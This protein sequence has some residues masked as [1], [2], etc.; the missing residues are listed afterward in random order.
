L[1]CWLLPQRCM[2]RPEG[3]TAGSQL[4]DASLSAVSFSCALTT[5]NVFRNWCASLNWQCLSNS[6][7]PG[8]RF[9]HKELKDAADRYSLLT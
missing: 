1:A 6:L 3:Q 4:Q 5:R 9:C 2:L 7:D 8:Q